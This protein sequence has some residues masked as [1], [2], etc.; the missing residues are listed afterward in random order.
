MQIWQFN[1]ENFQEGLSLFENCAS[2]IV[3]IEIIKL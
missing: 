2:T 1:V 3:M